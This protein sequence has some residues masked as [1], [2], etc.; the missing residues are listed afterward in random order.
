M[1]VNIRE[2]VEDGR[3]YIKRVNDNLHFITQAISCGS[4]DIISK[5]YYDLKEGLEWVRDVLAHITVLTDIDFND[6]KVNKQEG[7]IIIKQYNDYINI[8]DIMFE[9]K[10]FEELG[11]SLENEL[12]KILRKLVMIFNRVEE[13]ITNKMM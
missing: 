8:I 13:R 7:E 3:L 6:I 9:Q 11:S 2:V 5:N 1:E 10:N 4:E 12:P